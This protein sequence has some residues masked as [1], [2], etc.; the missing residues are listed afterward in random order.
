METPVSEVETLIANAEL[1]GKTS[2][3][4]TKLKVIEASAVIAATL[5]SRLC[6][7]ITITLF[8]IFVNVGIALWAGDA[9]GKT[10]YGFFIVAVFYLITGIVFYFFLNKW[11][12]KPIADMIITQAL[13]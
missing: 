13:Q 5:L 3:E 10:Y 2:F 8:T 4:L 9:L 7:I 12:K 11:I 1:Y 6:F